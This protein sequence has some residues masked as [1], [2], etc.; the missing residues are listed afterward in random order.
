MS[1]AEWRRYWDKRTENILSD[2]ETFK[3]TGANKIIELGKKPD[4]LN[5][6][7]G[8]FIGLI[9]VREDHVALLLDMYEKIKLQMG[10][11]LVS[12]M[13]MTDFL[14]YLI[15]NNWDTEAIEI[16]NGWL[17]FDTIEDIDCIRKTIRRWT[18][19]NAI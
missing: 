10:D 16:Q 2:I 17:E 4:S 15:D 7:Q 18:I 1:D 12:K 8:Q 9:K 6:I 13:Y 19:N 14:Q 11:N 3:M 5:E